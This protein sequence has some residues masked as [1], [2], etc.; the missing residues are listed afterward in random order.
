MFEEVTM[1]LRLEV[2]K[3]RLRILSVGGASNNTGGTMDHK[4][5][6]MCGHRLIRSAKHWALVTVD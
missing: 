6:C 2:R 1:K 3:S 5:L 4:I